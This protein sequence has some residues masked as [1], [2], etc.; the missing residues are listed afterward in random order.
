MKTL[1][2][3]CG[4]NGSRLKVLNIFYGDRIRRHTKTK[5]FVS[6]DTMAYKV[7]LG[8]EFLSCQLLHVTLGDVVEIEN[9]D[10]AS[11]KQVL[12]VVDTKCPI[13]VRDTL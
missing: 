9:V 1:V 4:I 10:E 2:K 5:F 6:D 11:I 13:S 3:F 12:N 7:L 8:R